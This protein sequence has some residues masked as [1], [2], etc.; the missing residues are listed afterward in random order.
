MSLHGRI[1]R[2]DGFALATVM[3]AVALI[4]VVAMAGFFLAQDTLNESVRVSN[5]NRAYQAASSALERELSVFSAQDFLAGLPSKSGYVYGQ[6]EPINGSDS[7]R[8]TVTSVGP[9]EYEM[10]SVGTSQNTSETCAVRFQA[11][12][13]WD[14]NISGDE[15]MGAGAGFNG[16]GTIIGK[17]FCSGDFQWTGSAGIEGGPVFV[18]NGQFIKASVGCYVGTAADPV[19]GYFDQEPVVRAGDTGW[20]VEQRGSAP[21]LNIPWP[22]ASDM[23]NWEKAAKNYALRNAPDP[24]APLHPNAGTPYTVLQGDTVFGPTNFGKPGGIAR[25]PDGSID[26]ASSGDVYAVA[27]SPNGNRKTLYLNGVVYIKGKLTISNDIKY[28]SGRGVLVAENGV[29]VDGRLVPVRYDQ[30]P[31]APPN[32]EIYRTA[33]GKTEQLPIITEQDCLCIVSTADV[34]ITGGQWVCGAIFTSGQFREERTAGKFRGSI[35]ANSIDYSLPNGWLVTQPG[36]AT[37]LP[38]E[39]PPLNN[40]N[41]TG[42]WRRY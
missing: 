1:K 19:Y 8:L 6:S 10:R 42:D 37:K 35:I 22:T 31:V 12:N 29:V 21:K 9:D 40:I 20:N 2:D 33:D 32:A 30:L 16:N 13:L 25:L 7:F 17:V 28:Y 39:M 3:G 11:I 36:L 26:E 23:I 5:E 24:G 27:P 14:M 41:A 4:T 18:T 15:Q 34:A 38:A